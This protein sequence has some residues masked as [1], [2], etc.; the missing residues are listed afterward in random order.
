[1]LILVEYGSTVQ[2]W[3]GLY[4]TLFESHHH[5]LLRR[6]ATTLSDLQPNLMSP[7]LFLP[8]ID[9]LLAG[10]LPGN[11]LKEGKARCTT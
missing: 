2:E 6:E 1:M 7:L 8:V 9:L 10:H 4:Q 5:R 3:Q 11:I